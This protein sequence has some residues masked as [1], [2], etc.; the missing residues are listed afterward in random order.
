MAST[1]G[2]TFIHQAYGN[3]FAIDP[4]LLYT[5]TT[6]A[7]NAMTTLTNSMGAILGQVTSTTAGNST[8]Y[9]TN[10]PNMNI[11]L[12]GGSGMATFGSIDEV[13]EVVPSDPL[14]AA[15]QKAARMMKE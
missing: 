3:G 2:P 12:G 5:T 11:N 13:Q 4:N 14:E 10:P 9:F 6:N 7:G 8:V 1:S 15:I